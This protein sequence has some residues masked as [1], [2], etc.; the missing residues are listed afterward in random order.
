MDTGRGKNK[1]GEERIGRKKKNVTG[2]KETGIK[3]KTK[4]S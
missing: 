1:L 4:E 3:E 2:K